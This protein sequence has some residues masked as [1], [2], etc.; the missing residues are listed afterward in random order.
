MSS[1]KEV[2]MNGDYSYL[3]DPLIS[4]ASLKGISKE[5][6][7][8]IKNLSSI[9]ILEKFKEI[10]N[11]HG[12]VVV[13]SSGAGKTTLVNALRKNFLNIEIPKRY[14][15]RPIRKNDDL[16]ENKHETREEFKEKINSGEIG[17]HWT[18][19]MNDDGK[20]EY[21]G[22]AKTDQKKLS[23]YS[24][25]N[26]IL[27]SIENKTFL[28][29]GI[30]AP[31]E[32]RE[33]RL[34]IRSPDIDEKERTY[35]LKDLS[36]SIISSSH[37]III[38]D[39]ENHTNALKDTVELVKSIIKWRLPWGEIRNLEN[40]R[41]SFISRLFTITIHDVLFSNGII[42]SFEFACRS[43]GVRT[44]LTDGESILM[45]KEWREEF[46]RWDYRLPG[47]KMFDT[48]EEYHQFKSKK[49]S[50]D[51]LDEIARKAAQKEVLE[52]CNI[53]ISSENL[54][55]TYVSKCGGTVEWDLHY[56]IGQLEKSSI[57]SSQ[58]VS[59][60]DE[61][62]QSYPLSFKDVK[63]LCLDGSVSEDRTVG[64]LLKFLEKSY[65]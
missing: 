20:K 39:K 48:I 65:E 5:V 19:I 6:F 13:G 37:L 42:K 38:N 40:Y 43:P 1:T 23:V 32:L 12:I 57:K 25:N 9:R 4:S 53:E 64:F 18:R 11:V 50:E 28:I 29:L 14:T 8:D 56:L 33:E 26:D 31:D 41:T 15:T 46:N 62:I 58:V 30:Y 49:P 52:E 2:F 10:T 3:K 61:I 24:G 51:D 60:E 63:K 21:Y 35:R 45:T 22:F 36:S 17:I 44:V 59:K 54:K 34:E 47:G 16:T 55:R 7:S 27:S